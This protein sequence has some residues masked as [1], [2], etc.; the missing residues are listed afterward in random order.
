MTPGLPQLQTKIQSKTPSI[1]KSL[2]KKKVRYV[3]SMLRNSKAQRHLT[4][5]D[6]SRLKTKSRQRYG[7]MGKGACCQA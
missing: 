4:S 1:L 7:S 6:G 5:E 3:N 2:K